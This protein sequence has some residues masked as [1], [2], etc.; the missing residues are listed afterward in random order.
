MGASFTL[1]TL[2][3]VAIKLIRWHTHEFFSG[4]AIDN[5]IDFLW[6]CPVFTTYVVAVF[7]IITFWLPPKPQFVFGMVAL[8][9]SGLF[10]LWES[11]AL[12]LVLGAIIFGAKPGYTGMDPFFSWLIAAQAAIA[13]AMGKKWK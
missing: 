3:L 6:S 2:S 10:L 4:W 7:G 9:F 13:M 11:Y 8:C 5:P 1:L 12:V